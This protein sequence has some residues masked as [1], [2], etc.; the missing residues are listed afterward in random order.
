MAERALGLQKKRSKLNELV[1]DLIMTEPS[2]ADVTNMVKFS[3]RGVAECYI[4]PKKPEDSVLAISGAQILRVKSDEEI[5]GY[6]IFNVLEMNGPVELHLICTKE[7]PGEGKRYGKRIMHD[8]TFYLTKTF[9]TTELRI[10]SVTCAVF[11]YLNLGF[12]FTDKEYKN[13]AERHAEV[14]QIL[15]QVVLETLPVKYRDKQHTILIWDAIFEQFARVVTTD[16]RNRKRDQ[17]QESSNITVEL[18]E[19]KQES[20]DQYVVTTTTVKTNWVIPRQGRESKDLKLRI[21]DALY[22]SFLRIV[23]NF[24]MVYNLK[25]KGV[26]PIESHCDV[27]YTD[28]P[29][30]KD[31][32][33][34]YSMCSE[35]CLS[36][37]IKKMQIV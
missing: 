25:E 8:L 4:R 21:F 15:N 19:D 5:V 14:T 31:A 11:Y 36:H 29:K 6:V 7:A 33:T 26:I 20:K 16:D 23:G 13:T 10:K 34:G 27:C 30:Y 24:Y 9:G 1:F 2:K 37:F 35:E 17:F 32:K 12:E 3:K 28:A 18:S 22:D